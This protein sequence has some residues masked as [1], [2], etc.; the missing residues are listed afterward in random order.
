LK[1]KSP[2]VSVPPLLKFDGIREEVPSAY[3]EMVVNKYR[4]KKTK[5]QIKGNDAIRR[6]LLTKNIDISDKNTKCIETCQQHWCDSFYDFKVVIDTVENRRVPNAQNMQIQSTLLKKFISFVIPS[7]IQDIQLRILCSSKSFLQGDNPGAVTSEP[8]RYEIAV[9]AFYSRSSISWQSILETTVKKVQTLIFNA[10]MALPAPMKSEFVSKYNQLIGSPFQYMVF[11]GPSVVTFNYSHLNDGPE[12]VWS[13]APER[14]FT[15]TT[16]TDGLR[17]LAAIF[18]R[19]MVFFNKNGDVINTGIVFEDDSW[20]DSL[21]DGEWVSAYKSSNEPIFHFVIFDVY[22]YQNKD[23]RLSTLTDRLNH[24]SH[25][26]HFELENSCLYPE[27]EI[28]LKKFIFPHVTGQCMT[29]AIQEALEDEIA[30]IYATDGL[31]FT[32]NVPIVGPFKT[33]L[34]KQTGL[35]YHTGKIWT[36]VVKWKP[37]HLLTV[38][39]KIAWS[40][41]DKEIELHTLNSSFDMFDFWN[42]STE[43]KSILGIHKKSNISQKF[44]LTTQ[45][46]LHSENDKIQSKKSDGMIYEFAYSHSEED[47]TTFWTPLRPRQDKRTANREVVAVENFVLCKYPILES[48]LLEAKKYEVFENNDP[49]IYNATVLYKSEDHSKS[50]VKPLTTM[51]QSIKR[52]FLHSVLQKITKPHLKILDLACGR[53]GDIKS[54]TDFSV[55]DRIS[56]FV[57]FDYVENEISDIY[58]GAVCR[59]H[60]FRKRAQRKMDHFVFLQG[61]C[62]KVLGESSH[63]KYKTLL[64]HMSGTSSNDKMYPKELN[65]CLT[66]PF[67]ICSIQFALHYFCSKEKNYATLR[68]LAANV[69][70]HLEEGGLLLGS[71]F[72]GDLLR[73]SMETQGPILVTCPERGDIIL[74]VR[75]AEGDEDGPKGVFVFIESIGQ[76]IYEPYV[77]FKIVD[78]IFAEYSLFPESIDENGVHSV[79]VA[80]RVSFLDLTNTSVQEESYANFLRFTAANCLFSYRKV[81]KV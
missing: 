37:P 41:E 74:S 38:D 46:C 59:L 65:A 45:Q 18:D 22:F 57:G 33:S 14:L 8:E 32:R 4:S 23:C 63:E 15:V 56:L 67:D 3:V 64:E 61:D 70:T 81:T 42:I 10:P 12:S 78:S 68:Q 34:V 49:R 50:V 40:C 13:D 30:S 62:G 72:H 27:I 19:K 43:E 75:S 54:W 11:I 77:D 47:T 44:R 29:S 16:K 39:F 7:H 48:D 26:P 9:C 17:V 79:E 60:E 25:I 35:F 76:E 2:Q 52:R 20:N 51:H 55:I 24:V 69:S 6:F 73:A 53:F 28:K 21:M 58:G 80:P 36:S 66:S 31:I 1:E 71:C 5:I